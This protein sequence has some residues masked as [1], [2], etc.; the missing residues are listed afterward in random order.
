MEKSDIR[1]MDH[2]EIKELLNSL[3]GPQ[4]RAGQVF[5]WIHQKYADSFDEMTDLPKRLREELAA[6]SE[7]S[8]FGE[9]AA[10]SSAIDGSIKFLY[11]VG[12]N[13]IIES[14]LMAYSFGNSVCVSTQAGCRM[15]CAFC[16]SGDG[17]LERNL[18]AGE[19][20]AQ[21]YHAAKTRGGVSRAVL[22]GS[23]EPLDNYANVLKFI[24]IL[25]DSR[26]M[27][28]SARHITL[29]TCG[30]IPEMYRLA[31]ENGGKG[32]QITLAVSLHASNDE[33]R[34]RLV[35]VAKKY[36][37]EDLLKACADYA[38]ITG[39]RVTYEYALIDGV[40]DT[41]ACAGELAAR[42]K[43]TL[44]HVNLIPVNQADGAGGL[45]FKKSGN[46][47]VTDFSKILTKYG[48]AN[49]IRRTLGS[50]IEGACGQLKRRY[51]AEARSNVGG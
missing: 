41:A 36:R 43:G 22:M 14:V 9:R 47:A 13:T 21:V 40:N 2:G 12:K 23:G 32:L 11:H 35:P 17:G 15:R 30:L 34:A 42:L 24:C 46:A 50:D 27:G 8:V 18:T 10:F 28:M 44:C 33:I 5:S 37:L 1:S 39:R 51:M 7:F 16:A 26:G 19:M 20:L 25:T 3:G 6:K 45:G 4:Y 31:G 48:I 49:T 29:S 38:A